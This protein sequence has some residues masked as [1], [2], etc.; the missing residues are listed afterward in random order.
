[1]PRL[2]FCSHSCHKATVLSC[3]VMQERT[4]PL[5]PGIT[6]CLILPPCARSPRLCS[7]TSP[8]L[9]TR[10]AGAPRN[11]M[12]CRYL[13][14]SLQ[15][16]ATLSKATPRAE[17][18]PWLPCTQGTCMAPG[19]SEAVVAQGQASMWA[20][21]RDVLAPV[22]ALPAGVPLPSWAQEG[23]CW[24]KQLAEGLG[25]PGCGLLCRSLA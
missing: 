22:R 23:P 17:T 8:I 7:V 25:V 13:P 19:S 10:T 16:R 6:P 15:L 14:L 2:V 1:M 21:Q 9:G 12:Q 18:A 4:R 3:G 5:G 24:D 20:E 11:P